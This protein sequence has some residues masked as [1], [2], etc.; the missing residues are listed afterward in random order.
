MIWTSI[1]VS[2]L[3]QLCLRQLQ[4]VCE[5]YLLYFNHISF[6]K[7]TAS[8]S[9]TTPL[10]LGRF[11]KRKSQ[12]D[13]SSLSTDF[14]PAFILKLLIPVHW[15]KHQALVSMNT[16][17]LLLHQVPCTH[18]SRR[19]H[20]NSLCIAHTN[21]KKEKSVMIWRI[22]GQWRPRTVG[23][24]VAVGYFK[25]VICASYLQLFSRRSKLINK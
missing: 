11:S 6:V 15:S 5:F 17:L 20:S 24:K 18:S 3:V 4:L 8:N 19:L 10:T 21:K 2:S 23:G 16:E 22:W 7:I 9:K 12:H 13:D 1:I 25:A 14:T